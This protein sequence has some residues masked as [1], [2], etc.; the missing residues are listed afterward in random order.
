MGTRRQ[1]NKIYSKNNKQ[2]QQLKATAPLFQ[3]KGAMLTCLFHRPQTLANVDRRILSQSRWIQ[4]SITSYPYSCS[5]LHSHTVRISAHWFRVPS[6]IGMAIAI[7]LRSASCCLA[8]SSPGT[9]YLLRQVAL[10]R[11]A[12]DFMVLGFDFWRTSGGFGGYAN[13]KLGDCSR[14]S[15]KRAM[16]AA[17]HNG[18]LTVSVTAV[19]Q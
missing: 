14:V 8:F 15:Q 19:T 18:R 2:C 9:N 13:G 5:S 11:S 17:I 6:S 3:H 16:A 1:K 7:A 10:L 4:S 12:L